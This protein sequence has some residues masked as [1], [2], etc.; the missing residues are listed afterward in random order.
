MKSQSRLAEQNKPQKDPVPKKWKET[1]EYRRIEANTDRL[2][3]QQHTRPQQ[4]EE[5]ADDVSSAEE[6]QETLL[7]ARAN[8]DL[9]DIVGGDDQKLER[10]V[11]RIVA[12]APVKASVSVQP[13]PDD[14]L[15][16]PE[17]LRR[18]IT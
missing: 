17:F 11:S 9:L 7:A 15:D 14:G 1:D 5:D 6:W 3:E 8:R 10:G 18:Q 2:K 4:T 13:A 12:E 16:I